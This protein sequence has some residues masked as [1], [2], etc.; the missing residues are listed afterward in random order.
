MKAIFLLWLLPEKA[1]S[2][3]SYKTIDAKTRHTGQDLKIQYM[4]RDLQ[5]YHKK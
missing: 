3:A 2:D 5:K 1:K 4:G